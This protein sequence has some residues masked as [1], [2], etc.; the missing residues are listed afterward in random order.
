MERN[1]KISGS[2]T[3][4]QFLYREIK[5]TAPLFSEG[6]TLDEAAEIISRDNLY[7]FPTERN[8]R[9][10]ARTCYK[11]L[12]ALGSEEII[13][14]LLNG[15]TDSSKLVNM[16]SIART[17][18]LVWEFLRQVI[19]DKFENQDRKITR[20]DVNSFISH[21][22]SADEA[23]AKWKGST[24]QHVSAI[25]M[26]F[27][28]EAGYLDSTKSEEINTIY[29]EENLKHLIESNHEEEILPAF[30]VK[31]QCDE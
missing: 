19:G 15:S 3:T 7:Q 4:D 25:L 9:R 12:H 23:A 31:R 13:N 30:H 5:I 10:I 16:Y 2:I 26:K 29:I 24:P 28:A 18:G 17:N 8:N 20:A 21:L 14:E 11:R 22:Q 27:L 6:K 1:R